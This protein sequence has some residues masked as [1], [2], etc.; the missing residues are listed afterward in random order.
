MCRTI[1]Y[2]ILFMT[3][4][5]HRTII[6]ISTLLLLTIAVD[7]QLPQHVEQ[8]IVKE[9]NSDNQLHHRLRDRYEGY[10]TECRKGRNGCQIVTWLRLMMS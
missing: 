7:H 2:S 5:Y 4:H 3:D 8:V 9:M 6:I 1:N 10:P